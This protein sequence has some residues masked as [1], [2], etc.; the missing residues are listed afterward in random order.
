MGETTDEIEIA[1]LNCWLNNCHFKIY[2]LYNPPNNNPYLYLKNINRRTIV[3]GDFNA[4]SQKWRYRDKNLA[5][6][7][8]EDFLCSNNLELVYYKH[9]KSTFLCYRGEFSNPDLLMISTDIIYSN[10]RDVI[11]DCIS[12]HR[13]VIASIDLPMYKASRPCNRAS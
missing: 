8:V 4:H 13:M 10:F 12:G 3:I 5:G 11:E 2:S 1:L 6:D 9:D 7:P